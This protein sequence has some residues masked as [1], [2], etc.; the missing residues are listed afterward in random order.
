MSRLPIRLRMA[1]RFAGLLLVLVAA[2]G[3]FLLST[4]DDVVQEQVDTAMRWRASR[5]EREITTD[6][7]DRLDPEDVQ[8]GLLELAPLDEFS[9][10]GIYVQVRDGTATVIA[11][12]A[13]LPRG[14]L[15]VTRQRIEAALAGSEGFETVPVGDEAVRVLAWPVDPSGP[16]V[17][18]VVVAARTLR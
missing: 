10:P 15:P 7:D 8:A 13:N 6:D 16:V 4:L 9:A 3:V 1:L 14:E 5:V 18:V 12:S 11:A 2:I 17:G